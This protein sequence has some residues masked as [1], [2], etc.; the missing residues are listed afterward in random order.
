MAKEFPAVGDEIYV[1]TFED[2]GFMGGLAKISQVITEAEAIVVQEW[3]NVV[4][5]WEKLKPEQK[6]LK[7]L[8]R[9]QRAF[10]SPDYEER[11]KKLNSYCLLPQNHLKLGGN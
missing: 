3:G 10:L 9:S 6:K 11:Q 8:F 7:K 2:Y 1:P 5:I 4:L